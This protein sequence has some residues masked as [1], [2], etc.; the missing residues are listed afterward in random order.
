MKRKLGILARRARLE[1]LLVVGTLSTVALLLEAGRK[2][3]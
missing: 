1:A 3:H 2:W